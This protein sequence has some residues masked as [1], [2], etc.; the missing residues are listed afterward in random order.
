MLI[1]VPVRRS[2]ELDEPDDRRVQLLRA[3]GEHGDESG[4]LLWYGCLS[5]FYLQLRFET[6]R[7]IVGYP[8]A[9]D[10]I[11]DNIKRAQDYLMQNTTLGIPA[12]VQTEGM[13]MASE[14]S[15]QENPQLI[16]LFL[17]RYS[18]V[19]GWQCNHLQLTHRLRILVE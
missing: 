17:F 12:L 3:C 16:D 18:R 2:R 10:W 1:C 14:D 8:V 9:W 11:S 7:I 19:F 15:R 5:S 6:K 4:I 13:Y